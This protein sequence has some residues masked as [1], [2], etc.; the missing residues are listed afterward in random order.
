L[1]ILFRSFSFIAPK[2]FYIIW[3]SNLSTL[4]VPDEGFSRNA[5]FPHKFISTF[6]YEVHYIKMHNVEALITEQMIPTEIN[7]PSAEASPSDSNKNVDIK[8]SALFN[9]QGYHPP[10]SQ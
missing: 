8:F 5:L 10:S 2:E 3:L 7:S 9:P 1:A 4:S 6:Y